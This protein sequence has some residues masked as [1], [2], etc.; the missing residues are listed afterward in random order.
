V[1][2]ADVPVVILLLLP[3]FVLIQVYSWVA[4]KRETSDFESLLWA[5]VASFL[6]LVPAAIVWH[7]TDSDVPTLGVILR[8]PSELPLRVAATMYF[9]AICLGWILGQAEKR[10]WLE[11]FLAPSGIDLSR[12][13][14]GWNFIFRRQS[15]F[16]IIYLIS[17][18]RVCGWVAG[19]TTT[20]RQSPPEIYLTGVSEW[21]SDTESW[22]P[23]PDLLGTWI[24]GSKIDRMDSFIPDSVEV[25]SGATQPKTVP[26]A[27]GEEV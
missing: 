8:Q 19:F 20:R 16:A 13:E 18:D 14:D 17:G 3:G 25:G 11:K 15:R 12:R 6:V 10:N 4:Y 7:W 1:N 23:R 27:K 24:D 22:A 21:R 5:L 26:L 9:L 2:T